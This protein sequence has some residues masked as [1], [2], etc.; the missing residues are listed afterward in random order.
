MKSLC[1]IHCLPFR[2]YLSQQFSIAY[3]LYLSIKIACRTRVQEALGRNTRDWRLAN[4]CP[5]CQYKLDGEMKLVFDMLLTMDGNN[6]LKRLQRRHHSVDAEGNIIKGGGAS[7]ERMDS[8]EGGG[9]YFLSRAEVDEWDKG[10]WAGKLATES[11]PGVDPTPCQDRWTN[12]MQEK[13]AT[14]WGI[15]EETGVFP[16][17]CRHGFILLI[18]DMVRSG[19]MCV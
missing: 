4:S 13:V 15:F 9:T 11:L 7:R 8:R 1:D 14:M 18:A 19:E 3:D 2:L 5:S 6:S 10:A 12:M 16:I 17:I